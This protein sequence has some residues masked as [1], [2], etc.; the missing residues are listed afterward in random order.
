V[1]ESS[2]L[3]KYILRAIM[4]SQGAGPG[5]AVDTGV[6]GAPRRARGP[7]PV[8]EAV[9]ELRT[10]LESIVGIALYGSVA[11]GGAD[12]RSDIDLWVLV[13][14]DRMVAQRAANEVRQELEA[15]EFDTTRSISL[16][17]SLRSRSDIA[18]PPMRYASTS[19]SSCYAIRRNSR[20]M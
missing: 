11:R 20:S 15:R 19:V 3:N 1:D 6:P 13:E 14:E 7:I 2:R 18:P 12:R 5:R 9:D 4:L 10:E 8:R 17:V 16:V